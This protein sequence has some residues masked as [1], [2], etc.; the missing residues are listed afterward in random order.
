MRS[1]VIPVFLVLLACRPASSSTTPTPTPPAEATPANEPEPEPVAAKDPKREL[2]S[3]AAKLV[4]TETCAQIAENT[5][6]LYSP[7]KLHFEVAATGE[8]GKIDAQHA[9]DRKKIAD[10]YVAQLKGHRF[11]RTDG[12]EAVAVELELPRKGVLLKEDIR[13]VVRAH[14]EEVKAC[15]NAGLA[16]DPKLTGRVSIQFT[17]SPTG[18]VSIAAVQESTVKDADVGRCI[19]DAAKAWKFPEPEGGGNVVVTYPFVLEAG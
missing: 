8:V 15:Y 19:A 12:G 17:I 10:C 9:P 7:I 18:D 4:Q 14:L 1:A 13:Q 3:A 5:S 16:R 2:E 6:G 11:E